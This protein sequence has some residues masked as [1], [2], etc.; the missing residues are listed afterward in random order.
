MAGRNIVCVAL[1]LACSGMRAQPL[2]YAATGYPA[3]FLAINPASRQVAAKVSLNP[4]GASGGISESPDGRRIFVADGGMLSVV[5]AVDYSVKRID[6]GP[7]RLAV[8]VGQGVPMP[9]SLGL[10]SVLASPDGSRVFVH[11]FVTGP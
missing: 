6:L 10:D 8:M 11:L 9:F 2:I 5:D 3:S 4:M 1:C 7:V